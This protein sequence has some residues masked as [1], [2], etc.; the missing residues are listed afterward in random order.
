MSKS[1]NRIPKLSEKVIY[2]IKH[3]TKTIK[4]L[5]KTDFYISAYAQDQ[6]D[7]KNVWEH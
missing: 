2:V 5:L 3:W 1:N 7:Q 6:F 4:F